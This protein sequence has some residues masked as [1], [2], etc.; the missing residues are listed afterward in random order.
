MRKA[1]NISGHQYEHLCANQ[2]KKCGFSNVSV[3]RGSGDQGIDIIAYKNGRRYGVQC[4]YYTGSVGNS[5]VQEAYAGA[6]YYNCDIA[7]VMTNS[8]FTKAAKELAE[9]TEVE[10][11]ERGKLPFSM[12][13]SKFRITKWIGIFTCIIAGLGLLTIGSNENAKH[14]FM[15]RAFLIT[16]LLGGFFNIADLENWGLSAL[17]CIF[18]ILAAIL[19]LIVDILFGTFS[20][21]IFY[22]FAIFCISLLRTIRLY[23]NEHQNA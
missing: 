15:Q 10:L 21:N 14:I 11:W 6:K 7:V 4:K 20:K 17:A 5:A 16:F 9:K 18:Y 2:L 3:T 8:T 19:S 12:S 13:V 23:R 22:I 1:Q